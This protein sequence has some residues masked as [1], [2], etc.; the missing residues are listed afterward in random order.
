MDATLREL[1]IRRSVK[2]FFVDNFTETPIRF[3]RI[4]TAEATTDRWICVVLGGLR[5]HHVS[6]CTMEVH[7]FTT[8][9]PEGIK[10][11]KVRDSVMELLFPAH[12][13]LYD[14][15]QTPWKNVGGLF[16]DFLPQSDTTFNRDQ[17][18]MTSVTVFL[19]WG[20]VW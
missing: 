18:R 1:N 19:K 4:I 13:P 15:H 12:I 3:D 20:T 11:S 17:S 8:E 7:V 16:I 2:K 5:P 9:D 10:C 6:Q 14:T